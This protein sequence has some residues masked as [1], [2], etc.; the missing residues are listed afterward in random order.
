MQPH[1]TPIPI[2]MD[3]NA[4]I[5]TAELDDS[6]EADANAKN[7]GLLV[8]EVEDVTVEVVTV[9]VVS[10][11]VRVVVLVTVVVCNAS[12]ASVYMSCN[13]A[14]YMPRST[15]TRVAVAVSDAAP[16]PQ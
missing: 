14:S 15:T 6:L 1:R 11:L 2:T 5:P 4:V 9:V 8:V 16:N 7:K 13:A 3:K 12:R 10:V